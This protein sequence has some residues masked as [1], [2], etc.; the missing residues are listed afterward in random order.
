M[1]SRAGSHADR[2]EAKGRHSSW[3]GAASL[4]LTVLWCSAGMCS[5][6]AAVEP[7]AGV[8]RTVPKVTPPGA[9]NFSPVVRD[10]EFL[11]TGLFSEPLEPVTA[12]TARENRDLAQALLAYRDAVRASGGSDA[13]GPLLDFLA[14]HPDSPWKPVLQLNLGI[15]YRQTGHFS[16]ALQIWQEGWRDTQSLGDRRGRTLANALVARLS[17]L[18]AY[19]GR[20][21]LLQPLLDSI[22]DRSI[23]GTAAQLITDS[24][25]GLYEMVHDPGESFRCGP[26]ALKRILNY[27]SARPSSM[28]LRVLDEAD[29]TPNGLSLTSVQ[30]IAAKAGMH[31]QMA[32]RS[33]GA[34]VVMPSV[35]HWKVGHYAAIVDRVNGRYVIQDTTFGEDIR[36]SA[37]TLDEEASGYFLVPEG[38]LP[39]GWRAVSASEGRGIWGRGNTGSN[40]DSGANGPKSS[41][42]PCGSGGGCTA[43]D[44]ELE[45]VG[46]QLH[47]MP[48][49]YRPPVGPP[50]N[51]YLYYSHRDAQQPATFSYTNFGPKWTFT[52]LSYITVNSGTAATVYS[53]GG[54][55]EPYTFSSGSVTSAYPGPYSQAILTRTLSGG[56]PTSFMLTYPDG[57]FEQFN[58]ALGSQFFM[59]AVG[60]PAGNRV[61]LTYDGQMRIVA[62]TD[63][64]GQVSTISYGLS[65]SPLLVTQITDPFGRSASFTY[66]A[67]GQLAAVTDVLG[68]TS[69]YT[70][71]QGTDPDFIN[72]LTTPYGSTTFTYGDSST[73]SS[74]GSTRFLKTVDPL[75]R[76]S[77]VEFDQQVDAGDSIGGVPKN[78]SLVPAGMD[79]CEQWLYYRNTFIFDPNEYA[80]A[81]QG[82]GLNYS[83][84]KVIHWLHTGDSSSTS[85]V[86][87]SEKEPL[88]NRIWYNYPGQRTG[89]TCPSVYLSVTAGGSVTNGASSRPSAI[90][91]VL[92]DGT[93]Q[94]QT[95]Q[96]NA[97]GMVT[98]DVDPLGR[99]MS[100]TYAANGIDLLTT[101]NTTSGTQLLETR[102]YN[103]LHLPLTIKGAN[104]QTVRYQYNAAG[105][106]TRY[107]DQQGH[108]TTFSYDPSGHLKTI[109]GP[110]SSARY[111]IAYDNVSRIGAVTDPAGET[112]RYTY[113]AADR[114]V[115]ASY[116]DGT[117][118]LRTYTLLDLTSFKDRLGQTTSYGY[119]ADRELTSQTDPLSEVT[120]LGYNGAGEINSM[121]DANSH[122]TTLVLDAQSR[123]VAKQYADSSSLAVGYEN[124]RSRVANVTDALGQTTFYAYNTDDTIATI[125]YVANQSTPAVGFTYDPAYRRVVNMIDGAGTTTYTYY[126]VSSSPTLGAN[127]LQ[128]V[129][130]PIAGGAGSDTITYT[131][132][133]LNRAIGYS[134]DGAPQS[135]GFD[136]LGRVTSVANALDSF[137][138]TYTDGTPRVTG[139]S[140]NSGPALTLSYF[141]PT[142]DALL[143]Q[144]SAATHGGGTSLAQF[145]YTY[146]SDDNATAFTSA[147]PTSQTTSYAYDTT[148]RLV[149]ALIGTGT[150]QYAYG[151]DGASNLSSIT[152]NGPTQNFT[153]TSTNSIVGQSYDT[154]GS[155]LSLGGNTYT[156]DGENRLVG[157]ADG[158]GH[159]STFSYDG[160][161]RLVRIVDTTSGVVTADHSYLWCGLQRCLARDNTQ[162]G[163]PISSQ[164]FDQ[165]VITGGTP[166]Y[167]VRDELGSVRELVTASGSVA[168]DYDY[169][170]YGNQTTLS[171]AAVSDFGYAGYFHHGASGLDFAMFRAYDPVR[172]RW[173]NRDPIGESGS[174]DLYAYTRGNPISLTDPLGLWAPPSLPQWFVNSGVGLGDGVIA[175]LTWGRVSGQDVRD[176]IPYTQG[177]NGG[178]DVCSGTYRW[179][180]GIGAADAAL[181]TPSALAVKGIQLGRPVLQSTVASLQ[182][183]TGAVDVAAPEA[184]E[185]ELQVLSN[186]INELGDLTSEAQE[187]LLSGPLKPVPPHPRF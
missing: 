136:A 135:I 70:Y 20:K 164:Y 2:D 92:D 129:T 152:A 54:G 174:I 169:D 81:T 35:A 58:Q 141:G 186:E 40:H 23:G 7:P 29:S 34:R 71:G 116:P 146:N 106:P 161:D 32:F 128:S 140:S 115:G 45:V 24:H 176:L 96:Y 50:V 56:S 21:E 143:Q 133:A 75:N 1:R 156:W 26:L 109:Q 25:T 79:T 67:S 73:N 172:A 46:L 103:S 122:T 43:A 99:T 100:Y 105:Q 121:M 184:V 124:G 12:T 165:G 125:S 177:S 49:G 30:G 19:L 38:R 102:T 111:S 93:T 74:L 148:N 48:V 95:F 117:T 181:A 8:N 87:E 33:P 47:D 78:L 89:G 157:F 72:T 22:H 77:Y 180:Y 37:A 158:A 44:V 182:L 52:W 154:N 159:A 82:G 108:V 15:I 18:E 14:R 126:P 57:S 123:V 86:R 66:N 113:D 162:S 138:Y 119:D 139:E 183:L 130:S 178:A 85:R 11:R 27:N 64:V 107:T 98:T 118:T 142:G 88:E 90:G 187:E 151:Y 51:F 91:R 120:Q 167:Y 16:K 83:L 62:I 173:L 5:T 69:N 13:V 10:A 36:A 97:N 84:A 6:L 175:A 63:A 39:P 179:S 185:T 55:N 101:S 68:I 144:I 166:Y 94:L 134:I 53:R 65:G 160:L 42:K 9:L 3:F 147:L 80:L 168:V 60:D 59:T 155:P 170:P 114:P 163:S 31:Y 4:I 112:V 110:I 145:G 127:Q 61:T 149:S 28:S 104:G 76:T 153:Y 131:Y 41:S 132:D 137:I 17:Q 150:P 171:G